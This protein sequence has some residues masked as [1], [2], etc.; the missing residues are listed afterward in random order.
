MFNPYY[1]FASLILPMEGANTS[2]TFTDYSPAAQ[3]VTPSGDTKISTAQSK[4]GNGAGYFDGT[5]DWL[6]IAGSYLLNFG[7]TDFIIGM[8]LRPTALPAVDKVLLEFRGGSGWALFLDSANKMQAFDGSLLTAATTAVTL[9]TWVY[10][11]MSKVR[12]NTWW[13]VNGAPAGYASTTK[14]NFSPATQLRIGMR[15]DGVNGYIGYMQDLFIARGIGR[16]YG[17]FTPP[18]ALW[19]PATI[20]GTVLVS[21]N[22]GGGQVV[23]REATTRKLAA[24][25]TPHASTGVWTADVQEGDYDI[26]Y[27]AD[28]CQ[29][30]CHGP[31]T[32]TA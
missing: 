25:A 1:E 4:W 30:I 17:A 2:T 21:G 6:T 9:D 14:T 20:S 24:I 32:I 23:V 11:E 5:G 13:S 7:Y 29:P 22:G 27:F 15:N 26:S 28:G 3:T 31:Y 18:T 10:I 19:R 12:L 16:P 8:W